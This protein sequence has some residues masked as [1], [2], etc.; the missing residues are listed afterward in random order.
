MRRTILAVGA[1]AA[2]SVLLSGCLYVSGNF[3]VVGPPGAA[4][5]AYDA[6]DPG[7]VPFPPGNSAIQVYTTNDFWGGKHVPSWTWNVPSSEIDY[8]DAL[9]TGPSWEFRSRSRFGAR[10]SPPK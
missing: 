5:A 10:Q 2:V 9:P 3:T 4:F 6:G 1:V 7:A 8:F